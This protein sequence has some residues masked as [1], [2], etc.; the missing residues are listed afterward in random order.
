[1]NRKPVVRSLTLACALLPAVAMAQAWFF[2]D[3]TESAG[4]AVEHT[5]SFGYSGEPDMMSGGAAA[6]DV[7]GDGWV[8]LFVLR[9]D[10]TPP[11]LLRNRGDGTFADVT[12]SSNLAISTPLGAPNGAAFADVDGNGAPDLLIGGVEYAG[13]MG[14]GIAPLRLFLN[15]GSGG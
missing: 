4:V 2:E 5:L 15:D 7:D 14:T 8:D 6:A 13:G 9:G 12:A 11:V 1:M 3:V 10:A